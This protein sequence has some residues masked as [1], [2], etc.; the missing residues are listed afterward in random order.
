MTDFHVELVSPEKLIFSGSAF[1][2]IVPSTNGDMG[3]L[4]HHAPLV[5]SLRPG[6]LTIKTTAS[7]KTVYVRGGF[8]E[9]NATGLS[10]LAEKVIAQEDMSQEL[11]AAEIALGEDELAK[12]KS[13]MA[14]QN[15][16][17]R[18]AQLKMLQK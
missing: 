11:I 17:L 18:L 4:A 7:P 2:V 8:A 3:I 15:A 12:A 13:D 5:A 10:L 1:E 9:V 16:A 14:K 6:F